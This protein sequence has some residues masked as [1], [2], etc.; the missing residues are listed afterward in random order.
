MHSICQIPKLSHTTLLD[1]DQWKQ[2]MLNTIESA[3]TNDPKYNKVNI[4]F[5]YASIDLNLRDQA[6]GH[7]P[8]KITM[9]NHIMPEM[10]LKDL[11]K[12][13]TPADH[14]SAKRGEFEG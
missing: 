2:E 1:F 7:E 13:Y 5:I 9:I 8:T 10:Y 11:E 14:I 3:R 6:V 12:L 4:K